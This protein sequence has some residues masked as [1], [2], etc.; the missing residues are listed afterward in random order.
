MKSKLQ[1]LT[2]LTLGPRSTS[3]EKKWVSA[4]AIR[5]SASLGPDTLSTS[6]SS[7]SP[8][9]SCLCW[10]C[11]PVRSEYSRTVWWATTANRLP[12]STSW[13]TRTRRA[14]PIPPRRL[15][16]PSQE[17]CTSTR[18]RP[19]SRTSRQPSRSSTRSETP[20]F[21]RC[22]RSSTCSPSWRSSSFCR[23]SERSSARSTTKLTRTRWHRPTSPLWS[24]TSLRSMKKVKKKQRF[25]YNNKLKKKEQEIKASNPEL[26]IQEIFSYHYK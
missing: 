18:F 10:F 11:R 16:V 26:F 3:R 6:T 15:T 25:F 23:S 21:S 4:A 14:P 17:V 20:R 9:C 22:S 12:R 1:I 2:S 5:T 8:P 24:R 19:V 7:S 13:A